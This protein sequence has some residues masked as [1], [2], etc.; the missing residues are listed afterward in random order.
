MPRQRDEYGLT[1]RQ[2][3]FVNEYVK[4]WNVSNAAKRMGITLASAYAYLKRKPVISRLEALQDE[5]NRETIAT[6]EEVAGY[7]TSVMR[8]EETEAVLRGCGVGMQTE[9]RQQVKAKDRL[10]AAE[11]LGKHYS[12]FTEKVEHSGNLPVVIVDDLANNG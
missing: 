10:K 7:L 6:A 5:M 8:G 3:V 1:P 2:A 9:I 11:L 12:M 4:D